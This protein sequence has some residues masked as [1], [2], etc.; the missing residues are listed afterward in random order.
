MYRPSGDWISLEDEEGME[1]SWRSSMRRRML[2][3][4]LERFRFEREDIHSGRD[5]PL[6]N[7]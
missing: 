1:K 3:S 7:A 5:G 4:R 6:L 2:S